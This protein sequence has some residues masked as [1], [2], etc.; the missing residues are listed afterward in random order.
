MR[1]FIDRKYVYLAIVAVIL[2]AA[3]APLFVAAQSTGSGTPAPSSGSPTPPP[4]SSSGN[5]V[6]VLQNPL[7]N[8]TGFC[9]FIRALFVTIGTV[10][11]PFAVLFLV[12][13]GFLFVWARGSPTGLEKA[14]SNFFYTILGIALFFA[15]WL[16]A[17]AIGATLSQFGIDVVGSCR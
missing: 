6:F 10:A 13:A 3:S 7:G 2:L 15:A 12:Y 9:G 17:L 1:L 8:I 4:S 5:T 11:V 14:K 16:L